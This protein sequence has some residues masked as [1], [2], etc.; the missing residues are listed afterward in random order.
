MPNFLIEHLAG[1][2]PFSPCASCETMEFLRE[3][4]KPNDFA[5]FIRKLE[6]ATGKKVKSLEETKTADESL[7]QK[8]WKETIGSFLSTRTKNCLQNDGYTTLGDITVRTKGQ[9]MR[10][11][12]LGKMSLTEIEDGLKSLGLK[13]AGVET[14]ADGPVQKG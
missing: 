3:K 14:V 12:N 2:T 7:L 6:D 11:P 8:P 10:L 4:L 5:V 13:F 9:L 1:C